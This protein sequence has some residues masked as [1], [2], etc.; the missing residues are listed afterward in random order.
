MNPKNDSVNFEG[1]DYIQS[2]IIKFGQGKN[3]IGQKDM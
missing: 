1:T 2:M 3:K